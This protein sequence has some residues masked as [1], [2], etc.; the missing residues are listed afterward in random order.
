MKSNQPGRYIL[1]ITVFL[2][3]FYLNESKLI[4]LDKFYFCLH[5][6]KWFQILL[7]DTTDL[8]FL[9]LCA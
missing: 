5:S 4:F 2:V 1:V 6:L 8:N 3:I 9:K 7:F